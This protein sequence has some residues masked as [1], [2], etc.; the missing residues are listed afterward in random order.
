M[1]LSGEKQRD[2]TGVEKS[3]SILTSVPVTGFQILILWSLPAD[4]RS[5][6]SGLK[7]TSGTPPAS[8]SRTSFSLAPARFQMRTDWLVAATIVLPSLLNSINNTRI[9]WAAWPYLN[10]AISRF[11]EMFHNRI[12]PRCQAETARRELSGLKATKVG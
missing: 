9:P 7:T 8:S 12:K 3:V 10:A 2:W 5:F 11:V 4:A 1:R 6:T